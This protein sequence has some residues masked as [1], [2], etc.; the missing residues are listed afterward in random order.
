MLV[1]FKNR[2]NFVLFGCLLRLGY[3]EKVNGLNVLSLTVQELFDVLEEVVAREGDDRSEDVD[4]REKAMQED[5]QC[6]ANHHSVSLAFEP[7]L[8]HLGVDIREIVQILHQN[9]EHCVESV[10]L[11]LPVHTTKHLPGFS[12]YP[13]L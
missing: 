12:Q 2:E 8:D 3:F 6:L 10:L 11:I 1:N 5:I 4:G 9:V 13:M 7:D